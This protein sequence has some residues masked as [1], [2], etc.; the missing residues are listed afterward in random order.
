MRFFYQASGVAQ[1]LCGTLMNGNRPEERGLVK[2]NGY[3]L[4]AKAVRDPGVFR[5]GRAPSIGDTAF[6]LIIKRREKKMAHL[7][8]ALSA[9]SRLI[10]LSVR[11][12]LGD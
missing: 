2:S 4:Y 5:R 7:S 11:S 3:I 8:T 10:R 9:L 1:I 6:I 12:R